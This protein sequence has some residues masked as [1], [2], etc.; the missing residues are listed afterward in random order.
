VT[1][2][3][4]IA[5]YLFQFLFLP[6][7]PLKRAVCHWEHLPLKK[8]CYLDAA[9]SS[10]FNNLLFDMDSADF[11][12][13]LLQRS[14]HE[15]RVAYSG[16]DALEVGPRVITENF[17]IAVFDPARAYKLFPCSHGLAD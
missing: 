8:A 11:V 12:A 3:L 16:K 7:L 17:A 6:I 4:S 14:G 5:F 2:I 1:N 15:V 13:M 9:G 10:F